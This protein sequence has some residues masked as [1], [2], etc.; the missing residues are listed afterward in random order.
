MTTDDSNGKPAE[1]GVIR[2]R[3]HSIT[4]EMLDGFDFE[5]VI[6]TAAVADCHEYQSLFS[7][8]AE[9]AERDGTEN[10]AV[11]YAALSALCG[12][13]FRPNDVNDPYG[14][15][16]QMDGKRS[17]IPED[18]R[19]NADVVALMAETATHSTLKARLSDVAWL[20]N[21]RRVDLGLAAI[22][23]Y[24]QTV[25]DV[26]AGVIKFPF[27]EANSPYSARAR[28]LLKRALSLAAMRSVGL[29]KP[30]QA[31]VRQLVNELFYGALTGTNLRHVQRIAKLALHYDILPASEIGGSLE[32]WLHR[33]DVND[34]HGR[35]DFLKLCASA[36]HQ[37]G[38]MPDHYRCRLEAADTQVR[39]AQRAEGSSAMMAAGLLADA[40]SE[41]HGIPDVKERRRELR[42]WLVDVQVNIADEM[43]SFSHEIDLKDIEPHRVCRRPFRLSY[44]AMAGSSSMA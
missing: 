34:D 4:A 44:A 20:L 7:K 19:G 36:H 17:A 23:A 24:C 5:H 13:H 41:L 8:A 26:A 3:Y 39:M 38:S 37:G 18:F 10:Y 22:S 33:N 29:G 15:M 25:R 21:R 32:G 40:I 6:K 42:H 11:V 9:V 1:D 28:D 14:P 16:V 35:V 2:P 27:E 12:F 30:E 31:E 43:G